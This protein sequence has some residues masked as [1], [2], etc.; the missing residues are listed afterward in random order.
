MFARYRSA[1]EL[2]VPAL[3]Q[4]SGVSGD[5]GNLDVCKRRSDKVVEASVFAFGVN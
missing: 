5:Y 3:S 4:A 2:I 1:V